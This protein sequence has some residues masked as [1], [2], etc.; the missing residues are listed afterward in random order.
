MKMKYLL[1]G[2][3]LW[4]LTTA[5]LPAGETATNAVRHSCC[6]QAPEIPR[7]VLPEKSIYQIESAWTNDESSSVQ[8]Q[9]LKGRPQVIAMFFATC[10]YTCPLIVFQMKQIEAALPPSMRTNVGFTL[11]SFD[12]KRDTPAALKSYRT[13]HDL[14]KN[15]TLL[16][17]NPDSVQDLA[18]VLGVKF[19]EEAQGEFSH[20]NLITL[21]N[22][23]GEIVYQRAGLNPDIAEIVQH[24]EK[25]PSH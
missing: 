12:S 19:K 6:S 9:S 24:I 5:T 11:V 8:L 3:A 10:Q 25:L 16:S 1:C 4:A 2:A 23:Q 13:S 20:S 15:W 21:L 17:G 14:S 22:A 7:A 18:A